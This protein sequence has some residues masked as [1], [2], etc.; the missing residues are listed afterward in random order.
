[1]CRTSKAVSG[2]GGGYLSL[3]QNYFDRSIVAWVFLRRQDT[4]FGLATL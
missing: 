3:V 4:R 1:M 2:D